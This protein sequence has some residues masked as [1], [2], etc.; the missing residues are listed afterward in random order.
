M[1]TWL[2]NIYGGLLDLLCETWRATFGKDT[3][4]H[5]WYSHYK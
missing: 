1:F 4:S 3:V 2:L 5:W